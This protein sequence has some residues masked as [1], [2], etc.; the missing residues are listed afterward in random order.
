MLEKITE[1]FFFKYFCNFNELKHLLA[2]SE[3]MAAKG[4]SKGKAPFVG[5]M[6]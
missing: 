1:E 6:L 3:Q 2:Q 5:F 4:K